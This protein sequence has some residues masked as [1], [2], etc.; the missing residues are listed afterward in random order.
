MPESVAVDTGESHFYIPIQLKGQGHTINVEAMVD[1]GASTVFLS[2]KI[3]TALEL[4]TQKFFKPIP[5]SN[6]D[7]TTNKAG[8][9]TDFIELEMTIGEHANSQMFAIT[10]IGYDDVIIGIDWLREHNPEIDWAEGTVRMSRC[11]PKCSR[12]SKVKGHMESVKFDRSIYFVGTEQEEDSTPEEDIPEEVWLTPMER[13]SLRLS[14][15]KTN[16]ATRLAQE[17]EQPGKSKKPLE[18]MIPSQYHEYL[19]VFSEEASY[20][21]AEHSQWDHTTSGKHHFYRCLWLS[22]NS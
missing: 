14:A 17:A 22:R 16:I 10:N 11:P 2:E 4:D 8:A 7:G 5:L 19:S 18:E 20:R 9:L 21:L 1:C 12:H 6:I 13:D 15:T 3:V